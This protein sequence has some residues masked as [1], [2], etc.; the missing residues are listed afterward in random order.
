MT[1]A[2]RELPTLVAEALASP[3]CHV[4]R[5]ISHNGERPPRAV[6]RDLIDVVKVESATDG[7]P[8]SRDLIVN[9]N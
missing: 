5:G 2:E 4:V 6:L 8:P 9:H 7:T 3:W 1:R